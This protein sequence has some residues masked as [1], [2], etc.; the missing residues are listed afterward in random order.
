MIISY[1]NLMKSR[2][3]EFSEAYMN[4]AGNIACIKKIHDFV[5]L[6]SED[7]WP[8]T[9]ELFIE[10]GKIEFNNVSFG[11][12]EK[13]KVLL[14]ASFQI[15]SNEKIAVVGESG[16]GKSTLMH[17]LVGMYQPEE[18]EILIDSKNILSYSLKSIRKQI[19]VLEQDIFL[20]DDTIL[21]NL[22]IGNLNAAQDEI[23][24]ACQKAGI[25]S[26]IQSLE[27]GF[28]TMLGKDGIS[29]SGGQKQRMGL[30]R[31]YLRNTKIMILDEATSALDEKTEQEI[32][33]YWNEKIDNSTVVIISHKLSTIDMC[34]RVI[35]LDHNHNT[36]EGSLEQMKENDE[37]FWN[38]FNLG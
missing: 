30:A 19:G 9:E 10:Q 28:E 27:Q 20:F 22:K 32:V 5:T 23:E 3:V 35:M 17:L 26:F 34:K 36:V 21:N 29:L 25:L 2:I 38:L 14:N 24:S 6:E 7:K 31:L 18:G 8:G 15:N 33:S 1:F 13:E 37:R 4:M 12:S 16:I 11:Y